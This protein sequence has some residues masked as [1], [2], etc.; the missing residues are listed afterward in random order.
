MAKFPIHQ[1]TVSIVDANTQIELARMSHNIIG[2]GGS[3]RAECMAIEKTKNA[4]LELWARQ[5]W[6]THYGLTAEQFD[7]LVEDKRIDPIGSWDFEVVECEYYGEAVR[8]FKEP[9]RCVAEPRIATA[10][11]VEP[12]DWETA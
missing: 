5:W 8:H 7:R 1:V 6:Y 4:V 12:H 3:V 10:K 9:K 11:A 2:R